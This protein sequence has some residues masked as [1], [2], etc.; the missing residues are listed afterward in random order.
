[1]SKIIS[2]TQAPINP[3]VAEGPKS[4]NAYWIDTIDKIRLRVA[5][6]FLKERSKGTVFLFQGRTENIE[7]YGRISE[8]LLTNGFETFAIDFRGQGLSHRFTNDRMLGHVSDFSDYQLDVLAMLEAAETLNLPRPWFLLCHSLGACIG[9]RAIQETLPVTACTFS[10]PLWGINLSPLQRLAAWPLC[11]TAVLTGRHHSYVP[12][13]SGK[14]YV[15]TNPFEGNR[16]T[17]D[18][19]MFRYFQSISTNLPDH[20]TGGPSL[21]WFYAALKETRRLSRS[22]PPNL[23]CLTFCGSN[24]T[25]VDLGSV[26]KVMKTWKNGKL[27]QIENA[28]HDVFHEKPE[29]RNAIFAEIVSFFE[30]NT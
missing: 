29:T 8:E 9:L 4:V 30:A 23:P 27:R 18:P 10:A 13:T 2:L 5:H 22:R 24:D 25:I 12:S 21:G 6:W 1:M 11:W 28:K 15:L 16:L 7:K 19:D 26:Q 14:S 20:Q 3:D 17:N